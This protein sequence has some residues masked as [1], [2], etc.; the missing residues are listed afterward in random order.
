MKILIAISFLK[1]LN[2]LI[3]SYLKTQ[4]SLKQVIVFSFEKL[5]ARKPGSL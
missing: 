3:E 2:H 1:K 4:Y 5:K